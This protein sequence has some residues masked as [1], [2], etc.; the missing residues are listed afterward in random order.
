MR[1]ILSV[2]II[3]TFLSQPTKGQSADEIIN[4][5]IQK[6]GGAARWSALNGFRIKAK[7]DQGGVEYPLEIVQLK[8]GRQYTRLNFQ[9]T[10]IMQGVFD[11][12]TLWSTDFQTQKPEKADPESTANLLL[13]SNDFPDALFNYRKKGYKAELSGKTDL[14][15]VESFKI[16]LIKEPITVDGVKTDDVAYYYFDSQTF[17]PLAIEFEMKHGPIR[18]S[19]MVIGFKDY[20]E[21]NGLLFPFTMTQ[22]VKDAPPQPLTVDAVELNPRISDR[23]FRF[24]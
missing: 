21:V 3:G 15:G 13:D 18:G 10:E 19:T 20:R 24:P 2:I 17:L 14:D 1:S 5:A 12:Q 7:F 9:D 4:N 23:M 16:K 6:T 22:G 8:D 11:G